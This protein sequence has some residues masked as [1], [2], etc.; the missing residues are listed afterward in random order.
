MYMYG[1][2]TWFQHTVSSIIAVNNNIPHSLKGDFVMID[3]QIMSYRKKGECGGFPVS[4]RMLLITHTVK[5][6]RAGSTNLF[7]L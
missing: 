5:R 1:K 6:L 3:Y 4:E 7:R 2:D